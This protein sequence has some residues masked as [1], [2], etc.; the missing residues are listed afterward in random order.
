MGVDVHLMLIDRVAYTRLAAVQR[1]WVEAR[2]A[3]AVLALLGDALDRVR[4]LARP[5]PSRD[6]RREEIGRR[7][8]ALPTTQEEK[9]EREQLQRTIG[10]GTRRATEA[11]E[12]GDPSAV[13]HQVEELSRTVFGAMFAPLQRDDARGALMKELLSLGDDPPGPELELVKPLESTIAVFS[14]PAATTEQRERELSW[15]LL[16][17]A[18]A[19][20]WDR[21]PRADVV[22]DLLLPFDDS[23]VL[24]DLVGMASGEAI[25]LDESARFFTREQVAAF[26]DELRRLPD[27]APKW[28]ERVARV[29]RIVDLAASD[30]ELALATWSG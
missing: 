20:A 4:A 28:P 29:R 8:E 30:P 16:L 25:P 14:D 27:P 13:Q 22:V 24:Q 10:E 21:E 12:R 6:E 1:R 2:D 11:M 15:S 18:Y 19:F 7:I 17:H 3:G 5:G 26:H 23:A 9:N